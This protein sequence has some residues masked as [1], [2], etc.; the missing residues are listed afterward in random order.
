MS[1]PCCGPG[2]SSGPDDRAHPIQPAGTSRGPLAGQALVD[3]PGG[4]FTMGTSDPRGYVEDGEGPEHEVSL[5]AYSIGVHT[6]TNDEFAAFVEETGHV[7]TA[8]QIGDSFVFAGLLP[9]DFPPTQGVAAAPW[10]R[11][12]EGASWHRPEGP[13]S[14]LAG[15]GDHPVVQVSW[16]DAQ[17]FCQWSGTRL[18][19]EAEWE[20]AARGGRAGSHF[21]WGE[22][23]EPGGEHRMN[24]W[25]GDFPR[26]DTGEDGWI[27]TCPVGSYPPNGFGLHEMT[28]N[29]WEWCA[30]WFDPR[31][32]A[33]SPREAPTGPPA[34][35]ARV[36]RGGS[37]LCHDSYCWRYRVDA[38]SSNTPD[39][40]TG[41]LGFRVAAG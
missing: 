6:V 34:G 27:G 31:W 38:R 39:S 19:T 28:G 17:A 5:P 16:Y 1:S 23:R 24:V 18:P 30:D 29:V 22:E 2:R 26:H 13:H 37:Y 4:S 3:V 9:D 14:D 8:E 25:Q 10:W 36:M 32:Y 40:T 35:G 41:N 15:R 11:L 7:S 12:V 21:P 33:V 20:R